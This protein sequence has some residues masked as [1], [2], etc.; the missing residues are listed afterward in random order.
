MHRFKTY[1][2]EREADA[3]RLGKAI[4]TQVFPSTG[5]FKFFGGGKRFRTWHQLRQIL[6]KHYEMENIGE[7]HFSMA[8]IGKPSKTEGEYPPEFVLKVSLPGR[9][10]DDTY[11][12]FAKLAQK[13]HSK[14]SFYPNVV[15]FSTMPRGSKDY[16]EY[17]QT[18]VRKN[19]DVHIAIIEYLETAS[20]SN[21]LVEDVVFT[22]CKEFYS[23]RN[24]T[25]EAFDAW[26]EALQHRA[27]MF[28]EIKSIS[29]EAYS[30]IK[31]INRDDL[32]KFFVQVN[33][34]SGKLDMH[35][36]NVGLDKSLSR[37]VIFDPISFDK[38]GS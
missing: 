26:F 23:L 10:K 29:K 12:E 21:R 31:N 17:D 32:Y 16:D 1:I 8:A 5:V 3:K 36:G 37:I 38:D 9:G 2:T 25:D 6:A 4:K 13:M 22:F 20:T 7:G 34:L 27:D 35:E 28:L 14:N 18:K 19:E 11:P 24:F 15:A 33:Q 30:I